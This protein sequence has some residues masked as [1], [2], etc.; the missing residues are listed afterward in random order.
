MGCLDSFFHPFCV[1]IHTLN[2]PAN[3]AHIILK[4][5]AHCGKNS[6]GAGE[7]PLSVVNLPPVLCLIYIVLGLLNLE[8]SIKSTNHIQIPFISFKSIIKSN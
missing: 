7:W 3:N 5:F 6:D 4:L 8:S 1:Q 2:F